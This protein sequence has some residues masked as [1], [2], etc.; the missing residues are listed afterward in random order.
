[1]AESHLPTTEPVLAVDVQAG[2]VLVYDGA[3]VTVRAVAG[4]YYHDAWLGF[5]HGVSIG[6][7]TG[8]GRLFLYRQAA[9]LMIR[10]RQA[11]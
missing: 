9:E 6:C 11:S 3:R 5:V 1:M 2:D 7:D 4:S 8:T 10:V